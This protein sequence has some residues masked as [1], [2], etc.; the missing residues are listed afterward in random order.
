M[1]EPRVNGAT[2]IATELGSTHHHTPIRPGRRDQNSQDKSAPVITR[3]HRTKHAHAILHLLRNPIVAHHRSGVTQPAAFPLDDE[4][5]QRIAGI[6]NQR[7]PHLGRV[8]PIAVVLVEGC[9]RS[10]ERAARPPKGRSLLLRY[11]II[12]RVGGR[13][14]TAKWDHLPTDIVVTPP[15]VSA[16][17]GAARSYRCHVTTETPAAASRSRRG[18]ALRP[19]RASTSSGGAFGPTSLKTGSPPGILAFAARER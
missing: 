10:L 15:V 9:E 12:E 11:L 5:P 1:I 14:R 8:S 6:C 3:W 16:Q 4:A 7:S 17:T 18:P 2:E 19:C 13:R